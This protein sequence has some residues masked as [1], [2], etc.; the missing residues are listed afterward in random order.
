M[1]T[2]PVRF[3][4]D[5]AICTITL[6]R[7]DVRNAVDGPAAAALLEAFEAFEADDDLAQ[8]DLPLADAL[9]AEGAGGLPVIEAEAVV[10]AQRFV[11][12]AGRHGT[13]A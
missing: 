5:D 1:S 6:D 7:P 9:R 10:G 8:W 13:P 4:T 3:D 11:D 12:G 2:E